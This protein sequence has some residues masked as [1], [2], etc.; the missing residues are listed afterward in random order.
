V[1]KILAKDLID[2]K[3]DIDRMP[4]GKEMQKRLRGTDRGGIPW[5]VILDRQ[6]RAIINADGPDGNIGCPVQPNEIAHFMTMLRAARNSLTDEDLAL[7][8]KE[9]NTAAKRILNR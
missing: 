6:G 8:E 4:G 9:L 2:V 1:A 7:S 5:M 3:I